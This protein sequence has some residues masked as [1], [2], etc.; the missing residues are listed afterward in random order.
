MKYLSALAI[1]M[2]FVLGACKKDKIVIT[3]IDEYVTITNG[4]SPGF[5]IAYKPTAY[6]DF[7]VDTKGEAN[8]TEIKL[9]KQFISAGG[10]PSA[11][12][13][14]KTLNAFPANINVTLAQA[15]T[16][17][18]INLIDFNYGDQ[19][20]FT[21]VITADGKEYDSNLKFEGSTICPSDLG[22]SYKVVTT[23]IQHDFLPNYSTFTDT[24]TITALG[25]G[26]YS[27]V[28]LSG[29]LYSQ[30]PY[31]GAY[32]TSGISATFQDLCNSITWSDAKDPWGQVVP[33]PGGIN[34]IDGNTGIITISWQCLAYNERGVS[35]YTP[36]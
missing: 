20:V 35:V 36:L 31:K 4:T 29:G 21:V 3:D 30:G 17:L 26:K 28:D 6:V 9:F 15:L 25:S 13:L 1:L 24:V 8:I 10:V 2:L 23:Y 27:V 32:G 16:G 11:K 7:V 22:G 5:N 34:S 19:V 33:A 18:G 12:V 14:H